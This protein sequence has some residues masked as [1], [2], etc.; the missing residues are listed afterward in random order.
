MSIEKKHFATLSTG[1]VAS[2]YI[3]TAGEYVATWTDFG[4]TW[5]SFFAPGKNGRKDDMLLGFT[6][7]ASD[8][9]A[10]T[11]FGATVGRFANRIGG[12]KFSL[13]GKTYTLAANDGKNHLHGGSRGFNKRMWRC[14]AENID[15]SP[16]LRFSRFSPDGEEGYP[17]NLEAQVTVSLSVEGVMKLE[18]LAKSD[19]RTPVNLTNHAYFNLAG[20]VSSTVLDHI[21]QMNC[22]RYLPVDEQLIPE[23]KLDSADCCVTGTP[24][25]FRIP[26]R[27]GAE[28]EKIQPG[29][30]HCYII[31]HD[32]TRDRPFACVEELKT[33]RRLSIS[34]TLPAVQFYT[35]NYLPGVRGK[36]GLLYQ[37]YSGF[38]LETQF[39]PDSPNRSDFPSCIAQ[40]GQDWIHTTKYQ[41]EVI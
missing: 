1:E 10:S 25:D 4:A 35:G 16:A 41:F 13:D 30:D 31:D 8:T 26:K 15:G 23:K 36:F 32:I 2:I 14:D 27:I 38:C 21:L 6:S 39:S 33:G 3:L 28:I 22:E 9:A 40:P 24:F 20:E 37:K 5:L 11:Y 17:G 19:A 29:Y 7:F 12:A 34:T 18:Y